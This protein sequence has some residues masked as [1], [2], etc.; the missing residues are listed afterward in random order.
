MTKIDVPLEISIKKF[1]TATSQDI[2][3]YH[4]LALVSHHEDS[5]R[6]GHYTTIAKT[7]SSAYHLF[8]DAIV[9]EYAFPKLLHSESNNFFQQHRIFNIFRQVRQ[10]P[11]NF[12]TGTDAYLLFFEVEESHAETGEYSTAMLMSKSISYCDDGG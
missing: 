11:E 6:G 10:P 1:L 8:D 2:Q 7:S 4:L 9:S 5:V 3:K 12:N